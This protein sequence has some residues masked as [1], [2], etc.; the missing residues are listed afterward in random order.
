MCQLSTVFSE[1]LNP[2]L[3]LLSGTFFSGT[4]PCQCHCAGRRPK[5]R[6]CEQ[7]CGAASGLRRWNL[8]ET[9]WWEGTRRK[10]QQIQH[11]LWVHS[12]PRLR[13]LGA[14]QTDSTAAALFPHLWG[15]GQSTMRKAM[16]CI[17]WEIICL[18]VSFF[19]LT[20]CRVCVCVC[21]CDV[22]CVGH[23]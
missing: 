12:L 17:Q 15:R 14:E 21:M 7:Q 3:M 4:G 11:L 13:A 2:S 1:W 9:G 22:R 8:C 19:C 10:Q 6:L 16:Q 23:M 18:N 20:M 5:L